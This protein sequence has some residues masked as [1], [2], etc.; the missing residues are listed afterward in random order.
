MP[1]NSAVA[2]DR[3]AKRRRWGLRALAAVGAGLLIVGFVWLWRSGVPALYAGYFGITEAE[4]L[5]AITDTRTALLAGLVG[6]GAICT[7]L[8]NVRAQ[9]FTAES[10][11]ATRAS[12]GLAEQG[13][14]LDRYAKAI[15]HL[16]HETLD[17]RLGGIY[18]LEQIAT[19]SPRQEDFAT[20]VE[21]LSAFV[22]VHSDPLYQYKIPL[23]K[24]APAK[25]I[26]MQRR[27]AS[28]YVA[29]MT[30]FPIDVQ[31]A[32]TVLG[33]LPDRA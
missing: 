31:A 19:E 2:E 18:A 14:L 4:R 30:T 6:V 3:E 20:A 22:R 15:N 24:D 28:K 10:L 7:F 21:V 1:Y 29:E 9:R 25:P 8:L 33:R 5:K 17:V 32:V 23:P 27:Q 26:S 13:Q 11:L 12:I 16:G